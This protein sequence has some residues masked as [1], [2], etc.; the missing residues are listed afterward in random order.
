MLRVLT[1]STL[2]PNALEP[3][4][5]IFVERQTRGLADRDDVELEVVAPVGMPLWPLS[6]HPR[7]AR[8]AALPE[9]ENWR[10]LTVHRPRYRVL[11]LIGSPATARWLGRGLLPMLRELKARFP[12]DVLDAEFFWPDGPAAVRLGAE[13]GVP[14][15]IKARGADIHHWLRRFAIGG[16]M[17]RAARAAD[18]LLA[19]S[20]ALKR[21]MVDAGIDAAKIAVHYTGVDFDRFG[22]E[23][24]AEAKA[25]LGLEGPV[26]ATVGA[27]IPRK[28]QAMALEAIRAVPGAT[29][30]LA[31]D[32][33]DRRM[34][35]GLAGS[36]G[37]TSRVRFLGAQPHDEIARLLAAADVMLLPS[38]SEGLAN[39]WVEA[40]AS[41]TPVVAGDIEGAD[42]AIEPSTGRLVPLDP[43]A[44]AGAVRELLADPPDP[45]LLRES[46]RRFSW[47]RNSAQLFDHLSALVSRAT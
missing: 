46:A 34:L 7:Y 1:L 6:K 23:D 21:Q 24:R 15:S 39:A 2:F 16:Q 3:T 28:G 9:S 8:R 25:A 38:R 14:V 17:R 26:I 12:F 20:A 31:G 33:P 13:L 22:R 27:L 4:L 35:E 41:G 32:G 11:P 36:L 37:I 42:E 10:G 30:I 45:E 19:V 29:L 47:E 40:L 44:L 18:G 5:G 43:V